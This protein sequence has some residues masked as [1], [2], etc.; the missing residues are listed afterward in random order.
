MAIVEQ[1]MDFCLRQYF[2]SSFRGDLSID[3]IY[4]GVFN[5]T[6]FGWII[7]HVL[8]GSVSKRY[9]QVSAA[10]LCKSS[11]CLRLCLLQCF[12]SMIKRR[13][14]SLTKRAAHLKKLQITHAC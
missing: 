1:L 12:S 4:Y 10:I 7:F 5:G 8:N 14:Q 11:I 3:C 2:E 9:C 13:L 6:G